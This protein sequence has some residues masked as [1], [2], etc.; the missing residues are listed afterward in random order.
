MLSFFTGQDE[1][2]RA[3]RLLSE[4][5]AQEKVDRRAMGIGDEEVDNDVSELVV[6]PLFGALSAE[7]QADAFKPVRAGVRKVRVL[8]E[9]YS[10]ALNLGDHDT[11]KYV[12]P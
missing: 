9:Y 1:I 2:E 11:R 8:M 4:A 5:V 10:A 3:A 7:A 12:L 6:V